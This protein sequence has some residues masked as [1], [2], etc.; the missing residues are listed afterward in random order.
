VS[1]QQ[2]A[3]AALYTRGRPGIHFTGGWLGPLAGLDGRKI[4]F[5][6]G[7]HPGPSALSQSLYRL[8][9]PAHPRCSKI[10]RKLRLAVYVTMAQNVGKVNMKF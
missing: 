5:P 7:F 2:H 4:S 6:P 10:S 3:P 9:Y 8:S 1:G